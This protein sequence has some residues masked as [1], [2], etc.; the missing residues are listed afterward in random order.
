MSSILKIILS[1]TLTFGISL[2]IALFFPD[3]FWS[4]FGLC[5]ALQFIIFFFINR[6]KEAI[7]ITELERIKVQEIAELNRNTI[8]IGCPC[9][10]NNKQVVDIR[11]DRENIF[12]CEKCNNNFKVNIEP[13]AVL[14]T[15]PVYFEK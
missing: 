5:S 4:V 12:E 13:K 8:I 10:E 1:L 15:D 9:D 14:T 11:F 6:N 7:L 2:L 3:N